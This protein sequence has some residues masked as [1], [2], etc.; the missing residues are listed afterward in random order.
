MEFIQIIPLLIKVKVFYYL[1][2]NSEKN[3][4]QLYKLQIKV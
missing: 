2:T 1:N 3:P 4:V